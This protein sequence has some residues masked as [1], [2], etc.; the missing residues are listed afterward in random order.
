MSSLRGLDDRLRVHLRSQFLRI[1]Q[2]E[3]GE[4]KQ[5]IAEDLIDEKNFVLLADPECKRD[6][7]DTGK[8]VRQ[9]EDYESEGGYKDHGA[10]RLTRY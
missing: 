7:W 4:S 10:V 3:E 2:G 8:F 6:A 1:L 9:V 5:R